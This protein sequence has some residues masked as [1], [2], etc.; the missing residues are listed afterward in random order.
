MDVSWVRM[1]VGQMADRWAEWRV[2]LRDE[3][4]ADWMG[5]KTAGQKVG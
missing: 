3:L 2:G 1:K 5:V 4:M